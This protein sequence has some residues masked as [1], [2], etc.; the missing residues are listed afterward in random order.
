MNR[1]SNSY[2][3]IYAAVMVII[4]A[5][6]LAFTSQVLKGSQKENERIDKMQQILRSVHVSPEVKEVTAT[7]ASLIKQEL[8][9]D[10]EGNI[11]QTFTDDK[12]GNNEAFKMN[13]ANTH[14]SYPV[15]V[16]EIEGAVKYIFPI[17]GKG[18]WGPIWGY[19]A[20][21]A[22]GSTVYGAD[23]SHQ[24]ETPGLGA[25]ITKE[26]FSGQFAQKEVFKNGTFKGIAVVKP[27][28]SKADQDYVDGISGGTLTS[29]GVHAMLIQCLGD[30]YQK[31]LANV[32]ANNEQ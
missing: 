20:I 4:V 30:R 21:D 11:Q 15:F 9:V 31:F 8:L 18:L 13:T 27:G 28:Q 16:A 19:L 5:I 26:A 17:N 2:T 3:I 14:P 12:I 7:Y 23:F 32:M 29:N 24:G 6:A 22:N 25:E 1:E 10:A